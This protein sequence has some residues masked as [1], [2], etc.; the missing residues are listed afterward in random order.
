M[1]WSCLPPI[2][3]RGVIICDILYNARR[4]KKGK[5]VKFILLN[6]W[7]EILWTTCN[8]KNF[9]FKLIPTNVETPTTNDYTIKN[10]KSK[11]FQINFQLFI[12]DKFLKPFSQ[13]YINHKRHQIRFALVQ[14]SI[15]LRTDITQVVLFASHVSKGKFHFMPFVAK[16]RPI[17]K[18]MNWFCT[19]QCEAFTE[20]GIE[21][22]K[23][24][25]NELS[26]NSNQQT[27][28]TEKIFK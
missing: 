7:L 12:S 17:Y 13:S 2:K 1:S 6:N 23:F 4:W 9:E 10:W 19:Q 8:T 3:Q 25:K 14:W 20:M 11:I 22:R 28:E 16:L 24:Y 15:K 5:T 26:N 27:I 21:Y 18:R